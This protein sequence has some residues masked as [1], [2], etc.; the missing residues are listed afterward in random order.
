MWC[1]KNSL[2]YG[3]LVIGSFTRKM[4]PLMHHIWCRFL[5]KYQTT[6]VTQPP[7]S[8]DLVLCDFCFFP[9]LKSPLK[10]KRF[11]TI[12]AFQENMTRQ[13]MAISRKDLQSILNSGREAGRTMWGPKVPTL[14]GIKVS[15]SYVQCFLCLVSSLKT[16]S[17]FHIS[18]LDTFWTVVH[19]IY[20]QIFFFGKCR[21]KCP[22][23]QIWL[24]LL[25]YFEVN[26]CMWTCWVKEYGYFKPFNA[27]C[28]I[29]LQKGIPGLKYA[30]GRL[31]CPFSLAVC[32]IGYT[33]GGFSLCGIDCH[34]DPATR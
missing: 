14:K 23:T 17:I 2:S 16:V 26:F 28:Q 8:P 21:D 15:L 32:V 13:L 7:Y 22:Y 10:E 25:I 3:Q 18:C 6:Q 24:C 29:T 20:F 33:S 9:K 31:I 11:Q 1:I 30:F 34:T 5:A 12:N 4:C 19:L 27:C